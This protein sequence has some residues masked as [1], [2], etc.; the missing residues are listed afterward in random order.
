[1][2]TT[3]NKHLAVAFF[4]CLLPFA[5]LAQTPEQLVKDYVRLLND[6]LD[7]YYDDEI[8]LFQSIFCNNG[9]DAC[10]MDKLVYEF[11]SRHDFL[12]PP[13]YVSMFDEKES[14]DKNGQREYVIK[15]ELK[16]TY[17]KAQSENKSEIIA[18][19]FFSG[20]SNKLR[21]FTTISIFVIENGKI[22]RIMP[23]FDGIKDLDKGGTGMPKPQ[24]QVAI[25]DTKPTNDN[26]PLP[27]NN[28]TNK[29]SNTTPSKSQTVQY[30]FTSTPD[31]ASVYVDGRYI[32][33]T[34]TSMALVP[35]THSI[36]V[37]RWRCKD[38]QKQML[39]TDYNT[40]IHIRL[41]QLLNRKFEFY[42]EGNY[43]SMAL[44][45]AGATIGGYLGNFNMEASYYLPFDKSE[46]IYWCDDI[47][48]PYKTIYTPNI[49]ASAKIGWG[50]P[51]GTRLRITPQVGANFCSLKED[52]DG[53][54]EDKTFANQANVIDIIGSVR[55]SFAIVKH[56]GISVTPEYLYMFKT[57]EGYEV[58]KDV[59]PKIQDW[60][61]GLNLKLGLVLFF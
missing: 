13:N 37:T 56:L 18:K 31:Y 24:Q 60:S 40:D 6:C 27:K 19:L 47:N 14:R 39:L 46:D 38:Y 30:H 52:N 42:I 54:K 59:S 25:K 3:R 1:M 58:L 32:G 41:K 34:S 10:I 15:V 43:C 22:N 23:D 12:D 4:L 8:Q 2:C 49:A 7:G 44:P 36:K 11:N 45:S 51:V 53:N 21:N 48:M 50:I 28:Q 35:G 5:G 16:E 57:S 17:I 29:P 61:D 20:G 9:N 33:M 55:F 26:V